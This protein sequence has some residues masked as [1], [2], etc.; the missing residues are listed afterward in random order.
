MGRSPTIGDLTG[1]QRRRR[2]VHPWF[3][4]EAGLI[5][6]AQIWKLR[7]RH[8]WDL[9]GDPTDFPPGID[10]G[11]DAIIGQL[12]EIGYVTDGA[13]L[14]WSTAPVFGI[15]SRA[16][17][18]WR[19]PSLPFRAEEEIPRSEMTVAPLPSGALAVSWRGPRAAARIRCTVPAPGG[20]AI[21]YT[22]SPALR[23]W[24]KMRP[25]SAGVNVVSIAAPF[26]TG[27]LL[28]GGTTVD[29][30]HAITGD[31]AARDAGWELAEIVGLPVEPADWAG[32]GD[33]DADQG[34]LDQG[35]VAPKEAAMA[36]FARG[37]PLL[38]W[39]LLMAPFTPAPA[40]ELTDPALLIEEMEADI[41]V[42]LRALMGTRPNRM[43]SVRDIV[44]MPPPENSAGEVAP[45]EPTE[46]T[47]SALELLLLGVTS[48]PLLSLILGYGTALDNQ[49]TGSSITEVGSE[50]MVTAEWDRGLDGRSD[51]LE[52]A[53]LALQPQAALAG[54]APTGLDAVPSLPM[55][56]LEPDG[57]WRRSVNIGWDRVPK[58][59]LY[60][61]A[62]YAAARFPIQPLATPTLLNELRDAGGIRPIAAND[63]PDEDAAIAR[64]ST[65]DRVVPI[66]A[67]ALPTQNGFQTMRYGV[68]TQSIFGL[69]GEWSIVDTVV[70]EPPPNRAP[71]L[72]ATLAPQP[73]PAGPCPAT[74]TVEFGWDW[75]V[76]RPD[77]IL[78]GGR[79]W[80]A[81]KRSDPPPSELP[82]SQLPRSLG[83]DEPGVE[84]T[85]AGD[86][87]S[88]P[89]ATIVGLAADGQSFADFGPA[90]GN[91]VRRYRMTLPG[92]S[93]D[94]DATPH[95][96]LA[97]YA[98]ATERRAP[99]RLGPW[100]EQPFRTAASDPR[101]P[102]I[103]PDHVDLASL[104]DARGEAHVRVRW[105]S[106]AGAA[107][108]YLYE[109]TETALR[110]A[111]GL[112]EPDLDATLT[113]RL[114]AVQ[115]AYNANPVRRVFTRRFPELQT[116]ISRDVPLPR[117]TRDIHF[118]T[119]VAQNASGLE[120]P[121]FAGPDAG[122]RL[123]AIT[124]PRIARPEP[125]V[126]EVRRVPVPGADPPAW[127]AAI[128]VMPRL[129][130]RAR[131][132]RLFRTRNADAARRI[133]T[134]GPPIAEITPA[135]PG[136][137]LATET[138]A[139]GDFITEA[140][141][142]DLPEGFWRRVWYRAEVWSGNDPDRALLASRSQPSPAVH[143]V[144][145]PA[146][147]P[148]L[149]VISGE[150]PGGAPGNVLLSWTSTAPVETTPTGPHHMAIS[151]RLSGSQFPML[152]DERQ[153]AA[154][155]PGP[156]IGMTAWWRHGQP[157]S[158]GA[159][160]YRAMLYRE[161]DTDP[162]GVA[163]RLRD[164]M[165]RIT[166]RLL[167]VPGGSVLPPPV[168]TS[169][170]Q[171]VPGPGVRGAA[172]ASA[173]PLEAGP[174]GAYRLT[175]SA[176][177]A[178]AAGRGGSTMLTGRTGRTGEAA[179]RTLGT[180][181]GGPGI[182]TGELRTPTRSLRI[183]IDV[184]DVPLRRSAPTTAPEDALVVWRVPAR[185]LG[186]GFG[187]ATAADMARIDIRLTAP[188]GRVAEASLEVR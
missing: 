92:F 78:I 102:V 97:L 76:R 47:F 30:V 22:G 65:S 83:G 20:V 16:F 117:G 44:T 72:A 79:L 157:A 168:I 67:P 114:A 164:P 50:F 98:R 43:A 66:P 71:I 60:R 95:V 142:F 56:P 35:L 127:R 26:M 155:P 69:W 10:T 3:L 21:A 179:R 64:L 182:R 32:A 87:P 128:R 141:G 70:T 116:G 81:S 101:P 74:L 15:P 133:D 169:L 9:L 151:A 108:Y 61:V 73:A 53:A 184:P 134:M 124:P 149:S 147:A 106:V 121:W 162:L 125:P 132:I 75:S 27:V 31:A 187:V 154:M 29:T 40:F 130:H 171:I 174:G 55:A 38:G 137:T 139:I 11:I 135:S 19:R 8:V 17:K 156:P 166:E 146:S 2:Q 54:A 118:F 136:W 188:D 100:T 180:T 57:D 140:E 150:W 185:G 62:S 120:S 51:P 28:P 52:L 186:T 103:V 25:L 82:T 148:N 115:S 7:F 113:S 90:Q 105:P 89:G 91:D 80:P 85:F 93:L 68:V 173:M 96:G 167:T 77:S 88:A 112:P 152:E 99:R 58:T 107:G 94:F 84:I 176:T 183:E 63:S 18:V 172:W 178:A 49:S 39:P 12:A 165:G 1:E 145:P 46:A 161:I 119:V 153:L 42:R 158:N 123:I 122:E 86:V 41:V 109:A 159:Q 14:R 48:D 59:A 4:C 104:P 181:I 126:L 110:D 175:I 37:R 129:G 13:H 6:W 111:L 34:L 177:R 33:H 160:E 23:G 138:D 143:V 5:D 36:R 24:S 163:I 45:T 170:A 144:I 131:R